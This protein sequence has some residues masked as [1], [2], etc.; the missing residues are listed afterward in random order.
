MARPRGSTK[1]PSY[2]L[3]KPT[4][5]AVVTISGRD[6]R[7][8]QYDSPSS[9][10][11]YDRLV[12][13]WIATRRT[14]RSPAVHVIELVAMYF[15][16]CEEYYPPQT[17]KGY[18]A[19]LRLF[20]E[21]YGD[22]LVS[23]VTPLMIEAVRG[24]LLG[25]KVVR[26][27]VVK[28]EPLYTNQTITRYTVNE[29][30]RKIKQMFRWGTSKGIVPPNVFHGVYSLAPLQYGRCAGRETKPNQ[31]VED[32]IVDETLPFMSSVVRAMVK[33]QR[34]TGMRGGE[35]C[36]MR[37]CDIDRSAP[38]WRYQPQR[39]KTQHLG[40]ERLVFIGKDAQE[41]LAGFLSDSDPEK[42]LFTPRESWMEAHRLGPIR[43]EAIHKAKWRAK[44]RSRSNA[45]RK[46]FSQI[47]TSAQYGSH[48]LKSIRL[49][50]KVRLAEGK[51]PL[52]RW[53]SHQLRHAFGTK[54]GNTFGEDIAGA[55]MG[56]SRPSSTKRYVKFQSARA[57]EVAS[58]VG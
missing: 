36:Q 20:K 49:A 25:Q 58:K 45:K 35:V 53:R 38:V 18:T 55:L 50:N 31:P 23:D 1:I 47:F 29:Y 10:R 30:T 14:S 7:L 39:H 19:P 21:M 6:Y 56:H 15:K 57:E 28:S 54:V 4:G 17:V 52:P 3:H 22:V 43:R 9:H 5:A 26:W 40:K 44:V 24:K 48:I 12:A 11:E 27:N 42:P 2:R 37:T 16:H 32:W 8:G 13:E 51:E 41:V 34:L 46:P 33:I